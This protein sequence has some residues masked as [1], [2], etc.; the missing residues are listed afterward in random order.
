MYWR[1]NGGEMRGYKII[2][3]ESKEDVGLSNPAVPND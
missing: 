2:L 1:T 3:A